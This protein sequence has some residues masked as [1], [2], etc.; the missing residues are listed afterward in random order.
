MSSTS[1]TP[2]LNERHAVV[3]GGSRGIGAVIAR[4]LVAAGA[5]VTVMGRT[6]ATLQEGIQ[7]LTCDVADAASV[8]RAFERAVN[9]YGPVPQGEF[10][11]KLGLTARRDRLLQSATQAQGEA[12]LTGAARLVDPRQMGLLFKALAVTD[13]GLAPPPPFGEI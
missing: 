2:I 13:S 1:G 10:L 5:K 6:E 9:A 7:S 3:T 8:S 11:L 12:I 4:A